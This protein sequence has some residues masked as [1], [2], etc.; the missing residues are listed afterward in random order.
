VKGGSPIKRVG[1][2][3]GGGEGTWDEGDGVEGT[4]RG[5][6]VLDTGAER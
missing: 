2:N 5:L 1:T 3:T 4:T 6:A